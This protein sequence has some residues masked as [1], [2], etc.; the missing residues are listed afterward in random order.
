M[1]ATAAN[2]LIFIELDK[3]L[4]ANYISDDPDV[5]KY[6]RVKAFMLLK[7]ADPN[8]EKEHAN[9]VKNNCRCCVMP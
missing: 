9:E 8:K 4:I 6:V 5:L 1:Y 7:D 3:P 2:Q